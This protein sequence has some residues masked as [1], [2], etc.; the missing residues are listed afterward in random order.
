MKKLIA[1]A[2][3]FALAACGG[4]DAE[5]TTQTDMNDT[6]TTTTAPMSETSAGTYTSEAED[7]SNLTIRLNQDGTY[8]INSAGEEV[9]SGDWEDTARGT[10]LTATGG[11]EVC[12]QRATTADGQVTFTDASG[13][14]TEFEYMR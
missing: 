2:G 10:C 13:E 8:A 11:D 12:W 1:I 5:E 6:A 9:E 14:M 7:G 3:V 4:N